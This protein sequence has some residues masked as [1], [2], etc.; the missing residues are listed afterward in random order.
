MKKFVPGARP[1]KRLSAAARKQPDEM[2]PSRKA[3][4][5]V[6]RFIKSKVVVKCHGV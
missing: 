2:V 3:H 1:P 4:E 6:A 5:M